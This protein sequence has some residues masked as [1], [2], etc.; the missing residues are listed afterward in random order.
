MRPVRRSW[1]SSSAKIEYSS[2]A[3]SFAE[4]VGRP[5]LAECVVPVRARIDHA[6]QERERRIVLGPMPPGRGEAEPLH[7]ERL[8]EARRPPSSPRRRREASASGRISFVSGPPQA[9]VAP[10]PKMTTVRSIAP[11][12]ETASLLPLAERRKLLGAKP[13]TPVGSPRANSAVTAA[14]YTCAM[15]EETTDVAALFARLKEE[16]RASGPAAGRRHAGSGAP[17]G[18]RPGRAAVGRLGRAARSPASSGRSSR[19]CGG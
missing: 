2:A 17:L 18:A 6:E 9:F 13:A 7:E 19:R 15:P 4:P 11:P 1:N 12:F 3:L 16:V 10:A 8:D 14:A 5:V